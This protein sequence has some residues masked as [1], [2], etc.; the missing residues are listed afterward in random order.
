VIGG[1]RGPGWQWKTDLNDA[2]DDGQS[3]LNKARQDRIRELAAAD[4][5]TDPEDIDPGNGGRPAIPIQARL[6]R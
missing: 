5:E 3:R 1:A 6:L 2:P 4:G